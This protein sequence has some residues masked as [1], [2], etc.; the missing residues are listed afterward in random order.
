[1]AQDRFGRPD[2]F[3]P[4]LRAAEID[5]HAAEAARLAACRACEYYIEYDGKPHYEQPCDLIE[6]RPGCCP[7]S[8]W[9]SAIVSGIPP[10]ADCPWHKLEM[11][12]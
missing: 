8:E 2:G 7:A 6:K 1:V 12:S 10:H 3:V 9:R 11:K 5:R 4:P